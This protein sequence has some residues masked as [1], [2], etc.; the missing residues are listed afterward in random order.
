MRHPLHE[1]CL[2][3][4]GEAAEGPAQEVLA[5]ARAARAVAVCGDLGPG[6]EAAVGGVLVGEGDVGLL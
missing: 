4:Y 1:V 2:L 6:A 3:S 5:D